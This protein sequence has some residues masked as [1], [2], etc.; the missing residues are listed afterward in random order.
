M[1]CY[2]LFDVSYEYKII[3]QCDHGV[4]YVLFDVIRE[5]NNHKVL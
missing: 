4:R 3:A 5:Q 2:D 1:L